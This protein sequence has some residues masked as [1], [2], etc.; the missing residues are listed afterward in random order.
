MALFRN[1]NYPKAYVIYTYQ[2]LLLLVEK[3]INQIKM[4]KNKVSKFKIL[5]YSDINSIDTNLDS[6][7]FT[8]INFSSVFFL[9]I[10]L[11]RHVQKNCKVK[12]IICDKIIFFKHLGT[13]PIPKNNCLHY[14]VIIVNKNNK[15][16][17]KNTY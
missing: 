8:F 16:V 4:I 9:S 1:S 10:L 13:F 12:Q 14:Y 6:S 7:I 2:G 11:E 17:N 5:N 15:N 3:N